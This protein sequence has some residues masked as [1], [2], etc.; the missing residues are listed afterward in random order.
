[1]AQ[2]ALL[3]QQ[4]GV[5]FDE[6]SHTYSYALPPRWGGWVQ[7]D[8]VSQSLAKSGLKGFDP[9][10]WRRSL[11]RSG[12]EP[13]EA[14]LFMEMH[15]DGRAM[16][17]TCVHA[18]IEHCL[19][20]QPLAP[21]HPEALSMFVRWR[22]EY[23]PRIR[24]IGIIEAPMVHPV[25]LFAGTPDFM[26]QL[27]DGA[28]VVSDWKNK[29]WP[30]LPWPVVAEPQRM[31]EHQKAIAQ[32]AKKVAPEGWWILQLAA[33]DLLVEENHRIRIDRA[34]SVVVTAGGVMVHPWNRAELDAARLVF[35]RG[36]LK[37]LRLRQASDPVGPWGHAADHLEASLP[38]LQP[39]P[40]SITDHEN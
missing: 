16:I 37:V 11:V 36:H 7:V 5:A 17:G 24:H 23:L 9:D 22:Q 8:S 35:L 19:K 6:P 40:N 29:V 2:A 10:H 31:L 13:H 18:H 21:I 3:P 26:G 32:K 27:T 4:P 1:M 28:T 15:R 30:Q 34:E 14:D 33:Y 38:L 39:S 20:G 25:W 12:Y